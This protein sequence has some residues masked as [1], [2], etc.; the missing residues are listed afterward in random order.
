MQFEA[1]N[2]KEHQQCLRSEVSFKRMRNGAVFHSCGI[3]LA[4]RGVSVS[5]HGREQSSSSSPPL[6]SFHSFFRATGAC[7]ASLVSG[8][9][10]LCCSIVPAMGRYSVLGLAAKSGSP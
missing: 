2:N 10:W 4:A 6:F 9:S 7:F 8:G 5:Q 1:V 3:G